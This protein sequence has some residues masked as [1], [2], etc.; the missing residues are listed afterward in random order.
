MKMNL[1]S[2]IQFYRFRQ[3]FPSTSQC[4]LNFYFKP[5]LAL[6]ELASKNQE[7]QV[8]G[9]LVS[10]LAAF[11]YLS[12]APGICGR[13]CL[14]STLSLNHCSRLGQCQGKAATVSS[15]QCALCPV[16]MVFLWLPACCGPT[17]DTRSFENHLLSCVCPDIP[18]SLF[19]EGLAWVRIVR[20]G[21]LCKVC[22]SP[23]L[24]LSYSSNTEVFPSVLGEGRSTLAFPTS[25][26]F[27]PQISFVFFLFLKSHGS[28][29]V[30]A[31]GFPKPGCLA[32]FS[33]LCKVPP[34]SKVQAR[35]VSYLRKEREQEGKT[36]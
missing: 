3:E 23:R 11:S 4:Q 34:C 13:N 33:L 15:L 12:R 21:H 20:L 16:Y 1:S 10:Y 31:F 32:D 29:L 35:L 22:L 9:H 5:Y 27:F 26:C 28:T 25:L 6:P 36:D 18:H 30:P 7:H 2:Q 19:F 14:D 17:G 24:T 8:Q